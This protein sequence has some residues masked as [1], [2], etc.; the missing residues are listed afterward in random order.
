MIIAHPLATGRLK[1]FSHEDYP[2]YDM[3]EEDIRYSNQLI[4]Y[5]DYRFRYSHIH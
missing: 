5:T 4:L 2:N 1:P 3:D